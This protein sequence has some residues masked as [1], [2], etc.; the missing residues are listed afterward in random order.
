MLPPYGLM[1]LNPRSS[2]TINNM[3]GFVLVSVACSAFGFGLQLHRKQIKNKKKIDK[4]RNLIFDLINLI[5]KYE[6]DLL[7]F[8]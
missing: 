6:N 1:S 7:K 8:G 4:S 5:L 3:F 2:A